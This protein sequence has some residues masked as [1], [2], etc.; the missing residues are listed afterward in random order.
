MK[1]QFN[2]T[3]GIVVQELVTEPPADA[4]PVPS[5]QVIDTLRL[6]DE[7]KRHGERVDIIMGGLVK[8]LSIYLIIHFRDLLSYRPCVNYEIS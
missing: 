5:L 1:K 7:M 6:S 4:K 8:R 3:L 2:I